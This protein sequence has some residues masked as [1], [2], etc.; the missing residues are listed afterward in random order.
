MYVT[1]SFFFFSLPD[2]EEG[3][4]HLIKRLFGVKGHDCLL[5]CLAFRKRR[6]LQVAFELISSV[7]D[8]FGTYCVLL[9]NFSRLRLFCTGSGLTVPIARGLKTFPGR[10][11]AK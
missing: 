7:K 8:S 10:V 1:V 9:Y 5:S 2:P 3:M 6:F 11:G 4:L